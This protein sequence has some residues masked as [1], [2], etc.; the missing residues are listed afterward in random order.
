KDCVGGILQSVFEQDKHIRVVIH[1]Q[2][3]AAFFAGRFSLGGICNV[4]MWYGW[5]SLSRRG[6]DRRSLLVPRR[7]Q[8][9]HLLP[10]LLPGGLEGQRHRKDAALFWDA[11]QLEL[12]P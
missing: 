2:H 11:C 3:Q 5:F 9:W 12:A 1:C 7:M 8:P 6:G 10:S 4:L